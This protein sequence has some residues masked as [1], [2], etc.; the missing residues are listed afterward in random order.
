MMATAL[1]YFLRLFPSLSSSIEDGSVKSYSIRLCSISSQA[2][3]VGFRVL[4][5]SIIGGAPAIICRARL[6]ARTTYANRL[7]GAFVCTVIS[8]FPSKRCQKLIHLRPAPHARAAKRRHNRLDLASR[9]FH[10]IIHHT[11]IVV[12]KGGDFIPRLRE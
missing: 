7:S 1:R 2:I 8:V 12:A 5:F 11:K 6:A 9:A 10:I 3:R 4:G